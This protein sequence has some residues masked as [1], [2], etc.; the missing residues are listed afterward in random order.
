MYTAGD[1]TNLSTLL[2]S[3]QRRYHVVQQKGYAVVD[4][5]DS[6]VFEAGKCAIGQ[7]H[8]TKRKLAQHV[9]SF[10]QREK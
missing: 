9:A 8:T 6:S 7:K 1:S 10:T 4:T 3:C 2:K 5:T